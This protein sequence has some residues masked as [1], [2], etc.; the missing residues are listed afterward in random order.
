MIDQ[1][2]QWIPL[3]YHYH[4]KWPSFKVFLKDYI[5]KEITKYMIIKYSII[6]VTTFITLSFEIKIRR[7]S[8]YGSVSFY[9][10]YHYYYVVVVYLLEVYS[11]NCKLQG[12]RKLHS[13]LYVLIISSIYTNYK[14]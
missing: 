12:W 13:C 7:M 8:W 14:L 1:Y 5:K 2:H 4:I 3:S 10:Y 11:A 9:H 6:L